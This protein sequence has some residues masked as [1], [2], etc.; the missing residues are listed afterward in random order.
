MASKIESKLHKNFLIGIPCRLDNELK[1]TI[2]SMCDNADDFS[3]IDVVIY[4]QDEESTMWTQSDFPVNI[5]LVN[6]EYHNTNTVTQA[7]YIVQSFIKPQHKYYMGIDAHM[8][9]EKGWDTTIKK[10]IDEYNGKVV[11]TGYP[12][13]Y[14]LNIDENIRTTH[15]NNKH[16]VNVLGNYERHQSSVTYPQYE[17]DY[18]LSVFAGGYHASKIDWLWEV[19]YDPYTSWRFEEID[20]ALRSFTH[21]YD[22]MNYTETPLYHLYSHDNRKL[23]DNYEWYYGISDVDRMFSKMLG[24]NLTY[25]ESRFGLG[26]ERSID[27]FNKLYKTDIVNLL[28]HSTH[29]DGY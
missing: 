9:F 8:V 15:P 26:K 5:T 14:K 13:Q 28:F 2:E 3:S 6:T 10:A 20:L 12:A 18:K 7:R 22:L 24:S 25:M 4:N 11:I 16:I 19:G 21:G 1:Y 23:V 27:D 17:E 29:E